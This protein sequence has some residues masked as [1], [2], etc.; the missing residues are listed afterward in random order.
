M[1]PKYQA[2]WISKRRADFLRKNGNLGSGVLVNHFQG[3]I[4]VEPAGSRLGDGAALTD[5]AADYEL[6]SAWCQS[7]RPTLTRARQLRIGAGT[8]RTAGRSGM[9]WSALRPVRS[10]ARHPRPHAQEQLAARHVQRAQLRAAEGAI[11]DG[12]FRRLE[13]GEEFSCGR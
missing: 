2:R 8:D 7:S 1:R 5:A 9:M 13:E 11:R 3:F 12:V 6:R 4:V 10:L